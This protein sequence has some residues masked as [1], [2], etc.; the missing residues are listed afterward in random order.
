MNQTQAGALVSA[1]ALRAH[2]SGKPV[3]VGDA[4][5]DATMSGA[6]SRSGSAGGS[7]QNERTLLEDVIGPATGKSAD[8]GWRSFLS[9]PLTFGGGLSLGVLEVRKRHVFSVDAV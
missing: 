4:R 5:E 2:S 7:R 8:L 9:A 3:V 6:N 1:S